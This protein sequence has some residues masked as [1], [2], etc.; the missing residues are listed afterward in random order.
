M[1][2]E[3]YHRRLQEMF[4][5]ARLVIE[6]QDLPEMFALMQHSEAFG[7]FVDPTL[8]RKGIGALEQ[9]KEICAALLDAQGKLQKAK[10]ALLPIIERQMEQAAMDAESR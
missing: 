4:L 2:R 6:L 8:W 5:A 1:E 10:A 7:C 9:H 3:L